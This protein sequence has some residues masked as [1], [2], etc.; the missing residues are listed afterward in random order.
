MVLWIYIVTVIRNNVITKL[1][2][3]INLSVNTNSKLHAVPLLLDIR[4]TKNSS[5]GK[6]TRAHIPNSLS[7]IPLYIIINILQAVYLGETVW[8]GV[9]GL[10]M[11]AVN[12]DLHNCLLFQNDDYH[13]TQP[14]VNNYC[15]V[16]KSLNPLCWSGLWREKSLAQ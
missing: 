3:Q 9:L 5:W 15:N 7:N 11:I 13:K 16:N 4:V 1:I 2:N 8:Q 10:Q 6:Q 14:M 12:A